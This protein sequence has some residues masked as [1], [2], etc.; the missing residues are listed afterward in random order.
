MGSKIA[1]KKVCDVFSFKNILQIKLTFHLESAIMQNKN[2]QVLE[3][4]KKAK[5]FFLFEKNYVSLHGNYVETQTSRNY[6]KSQTSRNKNASS[7]VI[8]TS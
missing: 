6:A 4:V 2:A 5:L 1:H 3:P 7:C 8:I